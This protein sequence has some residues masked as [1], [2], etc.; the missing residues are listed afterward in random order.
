M[1]AIAGRLL[2]WEK[3]FTLSDFSGARHTHT[4][5]QLMRFSTTRDDKQQPSQT[6]V[7]HNNTNTAHND[8]TE[9]ITLATE[10]PRTGQDTAIYHERASSWFRTMPRGST[11]SRSFVGSVDWMSTPKVA[12]PGGWLCRHTW[13]APVNFAMIVRVCVCVELTVDKVWQD[14]HHWFQIRVCQWT[15]VEKLSFMEDN[16]MEALWYVLSCCFLIVRCRNQ[17]F[18]P[19]INTESFWPLLQYKCMKAWHRAKTF[20]IPTFTFKIF[21]HPL[22]DLNRR[23]QVCEFSALFDWS[24]RVERTVSYKKFLVFIG[25]FLIYRKNVFMLMPF[26]FI[27]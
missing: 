7:Q 22:W 16:G 12:G 9:A 23:L 21:W 2:L 15:K 11:P 8:A 10:P 20:L 1:F 27:L 14:L 19:A 24:T 5:S 25:F 13:S 3:K 18:D 4:P 6:Q 26:T 17:G